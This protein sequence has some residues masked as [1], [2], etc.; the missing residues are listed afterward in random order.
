MGLPGLYWGGCDVLGMLGVWM[1]GGFGC[2]SVFAA[3]GSVAA[4]SG[5]RWKCGSP[6]RVEAGDDILYSK[7]SLWRVWDGISR[8][9]SSVCILVNMCK[10]LYL[11]LCVFVVW[12]ALAREGVHLVG[13]LMVGG[14]VCRKGGKVLR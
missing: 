2:L 7:V 6:L 9:S 14:L 12:V 8:L 5:V 13:G 1:S 3:G 10:F 11:Q 4:E